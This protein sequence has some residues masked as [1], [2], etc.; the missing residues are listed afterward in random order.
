[1]SGA[2]SLA[3]RDHVGWSIDGVPPLGAHVPASAIVEALTVNDTNVHEVVSQSETVR[4][5]GLPQG[6]WQRGSEYGV[7]VGGEQELPCGAAHVQ[8]EQVADGALNPS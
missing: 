6:V 1:V 3:T 8:F 4:G 7:M 2:H 5:S